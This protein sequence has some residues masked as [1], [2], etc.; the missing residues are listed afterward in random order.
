MAESR[1]LPFKETNAEDA[2]SDLATRFA[3]D[4]YLFVTDLIEKSKIERLGARIIDELKAHGFVTQETTSIPIWSGKAPEADEVLPEGPIITALA[5]TGMLSDLS[6]SPELIALLER[7]LGG[8]IFAWKDSD[9][10]LRIVLGPTANRE[11][12]TDA[13]KFSFSTPPHQD[14]YF[15]RP[16]RFCTVWIPLMHI[17]ETTGGLTLR[18][19]AHREGLHETWWKGNE[20]LGMAETPRISREWVE[21]G[22]VPVAGTT[23][24]EEADQAKPW[25]RSDFQIGDV[26]II[27][28]LMIHA[29]VP[30][31]SNLIRLS[32][33]FR[34][35]LQGTQTHWESHNTMEYAGEY[36]TSVL[37][38]LD[39]QDLEP[40]VYENVWEKMRLAGPDDRADIP[41]RVKTLVEEMQ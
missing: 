15:F 20:F 11:G 24:P 40:G 17:D 8:E 31:H 22:A 14:F 2:A 32:A 26:L 39:D 35:Q 41:D 25:L 7:V 28:P 27:D 16:V 6:R 10:R 4:G 1:F 5:Q 37:E 23:R 18:Q 34:Y 12:S 36:F 19:D 30:N 33:D 13:P 21:S 9:A 38:C 3:E 29:G